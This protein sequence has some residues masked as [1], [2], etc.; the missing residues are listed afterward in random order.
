MKKNFENWNFKEFGNYIFLNNYSLFKR[1]K[2][3]FFQLEQYDKPFFY[4]QII[5][6]YILSNIGI[7]DKD[8]FLILQIILKFVFIF[9]LKYQSHVTLKYYYVTDNSTST[10][11][12]QKNFVPNTIQIQSFT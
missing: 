5:D 6:K 1:N 11:R 10:V 9:S 12:S 4:S 2:E 3:Y 8:I 7:S